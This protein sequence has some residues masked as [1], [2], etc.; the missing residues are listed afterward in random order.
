MIRFLLEN[1]SNINYVNQSKRT[2][3]QDLALEGNLK[4]FKLL[5]IRQPNLSHSDLYLKKMC[6]LMLL[7]VET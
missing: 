5:M 1:G 2:I 7:K 4:A 6:C 3:M